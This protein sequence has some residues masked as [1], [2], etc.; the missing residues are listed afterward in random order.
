LNQAEISKSARSYV[1]SNLKEMQAGCR[2]RSFARQEARGAYKGRLSHG[3]E[4][5]D[6]PLP[7]SLKYF[8]VAGEK[9]AVPLRPHPGPRILE[10]PPITH[11]LFREAGADH[12]FDFIYGIICVLDSNDTGGGRDSLWSKL[13]QRLKKFSRGVAICSRNS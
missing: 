6:E 5:T 12:N 10:V 9:R 7:P 4:Q 8:E 1:S 2:L 13:L 3:Y 11:W